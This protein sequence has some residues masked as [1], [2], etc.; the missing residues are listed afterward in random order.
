MNAL[1]SGSG[2]S[3]GGGKGDR[4]VTLATIKEEALGTNSTNAWVQVCSLHLLPCSSQ[5]SSSV[6]AWEEGAAVGMSM[7]GCLQ[8][9]PYV[10]HNFDAR[11]CRSPQ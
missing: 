10:F 2:A 11:L 3:V 8:R 4:R 7:D 5:S 6:T 9:L 1:T